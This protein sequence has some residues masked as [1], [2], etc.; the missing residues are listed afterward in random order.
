[1]EKMLL[2]VSEV[3]QIL[4][5]GRSMTYNLIYQKVIPS[6]RLGRSI[7]VPKESLERWIQ[8]NEIRTTDVN[9]K[10]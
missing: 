1:M 9:E 7:R 10:E 5:I 3:A 2:K 6:I 8:D 4:G